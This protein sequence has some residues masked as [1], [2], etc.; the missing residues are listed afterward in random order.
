[1]QRT[2]ALVLIALTLVFSACKSNNNNENSPEPTDEA[3]ATPSVQSSG[4]FQ[5]VGAAQHAF[6]GIGP[7]I[8]LS[9]AEA[10][11]A[12]TDSTDF[13]ASASPEVTTSG[14]SES[15]TPSQF[16]VMRV[17]IDDANDALKSTC[18]A[19]RDGKVNVFWTTS[20]QFDASLL[21]DDLES[22]LEG[23]TV[24]IVGRI[25]MTSGDTT[26]DTSLLGDTTASPDESPSETAS[27]VN[28]D[29]VLV[30]DQIG[31]SSGTIPTPAQ[32]RAPVVT[33][34]PTATPTATPAPTSTATTSPSA[35]T[36]TAPS[37]SPTLSPSST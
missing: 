4:D 18:S 8:D 12:A 3:T 22:A 24:G 16:G 30:A 14:S 29:C 21:S 27:P 28:P 26:G 34:A 10:A 20:T 25:F 35:T 31:T 23:R 1:M 15:S 33:T 19:D 32:R 11:P 5:L 37:A 36:T 13:N 2:F 7:G 9:A 17:L 6:V